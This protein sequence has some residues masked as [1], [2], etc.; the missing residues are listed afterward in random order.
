MEIFLRHEYQESACKAKV[1]SA[2]IG[3]KFVISICLQIC[4]IVVE[5]GISHP[6]PF[7][8]SLYCFD[9]SVAQGRQFRN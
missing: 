4:L 5:V 7:F 1:A 6:P 3:L 9:P 8:P 2:K